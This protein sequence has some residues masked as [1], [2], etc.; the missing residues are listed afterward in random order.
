MASGSLEID[1]ESIRVTTDYM[2]TELGVVEARL[3]SLDS[4]IAALENEVA[5]HRSEIEEWEDWVDRQLR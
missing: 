1:P 4:E 2:A 3:R 5:R